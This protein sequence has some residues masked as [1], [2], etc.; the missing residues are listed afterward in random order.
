MPVQLPSEIYLDAPRYEIVEWAK[1]NQVSF[2]IYGSRDSTVRPL[3]DWVKSV[4]AALPTR[5]P[6]DD[7]FAP[8]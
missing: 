6:P 7:V 4:A 3:I 8:R 5:K 1:M 2:S